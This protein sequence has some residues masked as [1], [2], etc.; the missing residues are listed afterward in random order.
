[1]VV[2]ESRVP[3]LNWIQ[4]IFY[5]E[6]YH[7]SLSR[8]GYVF[9]SSSIFHFLL[10][11]LVWLSQDVQMI[12]EIIKIVLLVNLIAWNGWSTTFIYKARWQSLHFTQHASAGNAN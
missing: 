5:F 6:L 1:L 8:K 7:R 10:S 12:T 9:K 3:V 4:W 11:K 2:R